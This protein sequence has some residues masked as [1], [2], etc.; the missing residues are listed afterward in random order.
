ML[1]GFTSGQASIELPWVFSGLHFIIRRREGRARRLLSFPRRH[2]ISIISSSP[3]LARRFTCPSLY[4]QTRTVIAPEKYFWISVQRDSSIFK[5]HLSIND[6]FLC[7]QGLFWG[8]LTWWWH[9]WAG[10]RP[11]CLSNSLAR[12]TFGEG[13]GTPLRYSCLKTPMDGGAW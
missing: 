6:C 2:H 10:C 5:S 13:N 8:S 7:A 12:L 1:A 3:R 11:V 4:G 9:Y